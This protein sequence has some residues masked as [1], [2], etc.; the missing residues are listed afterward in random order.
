[1]EIWIQA[2]QHGHMDY[3]RFHKESHYL[4]DHRLRPGFHRPPVDKRIESPAVYF[5]RITFQL[6]NRCMPPSAQ[7]GYRH[8]YR[9]GNIDAVEMDKACP[10]AFVL[11]TIGCSAIPE[12]VWVSRRAAMFSYQA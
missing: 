5:L 8:G 4:Y 12:I 11:L 3:N 9:H 7:N 2:Y 10:H 1:M 6:I